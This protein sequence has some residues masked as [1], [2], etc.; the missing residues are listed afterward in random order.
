MN[1][2]ILF[3]FQDGVRNKLSPSFTPDYVE[4]RDN[5][6][7]LTCKEKFDKLILICGKHEYENGLPFP[8]LMYHSS[9]KLLDLVPDYTLLNGLNIP[10]KEIMWKKTL[11]VSDNKHIMKTICSSDRIT[12][13]GNLLTFEIVPFISDLLF[14]WMYEGSIKTHIECF[15]DCTPEMKQKAL[16]ELKQIGI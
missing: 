14:E 3:G 8:Y 10:Q 16:E 12:V 15:G 13:C 4:V 9:N 6:R 7:L 11:K 1:T 2:L 5:I